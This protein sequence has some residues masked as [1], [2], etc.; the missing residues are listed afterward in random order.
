MLRSASQSLIRLMAAGADRLLPSDG[1]TIKNLVATAVVEGMTDE[2][3]KKAMAVF[4]MEHRRRTATHIETVTFNNFVE[5]ETARMFDGALFDSGGVNLWSHGREPVALDEQNVIRMNRDTL[6]SAA[7]V[8]ISRG[9]TVTLPEAGERYRS[10]M[11]LNEGHYVNAIYHDAG[12]YEL[13]VDDFDTDYVAVVVRTF[14]DPGDPADL[15]EVHAL[16]D[17]MM[18]EAGSAKPYEHPLFDEAS[19]KTV[20]DALLILNEGGSDSARTFGKKTEVDPVR[21]LLG[22][23]AG[24]GGL[25]ESEAFYSIDTEPRPLGRYTLTLKD[26]PVDGFWSLSIYNRD[27]FFEEN[28]YDSYSLNNVTAMA[29]KD[30]TVTLNLSPEDAGLTNHLYIMDGWNYALRLYRPR[31]EIVDGT[32]T[33]PT[34]E[35]VA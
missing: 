4:G 24:W 33:P 25:P 26:V 12:S 16:Q 31:P 23:A 21:H 29:N 8:D 5:A 3:V 34:P 20:C 32:W 14:V 30:G 10:M 7:I 18:L 6:Y 15:E 19:R 28:R 11:V 2:Q 13:T 9:A 35:M 17:S 27:G 22:T 1:D